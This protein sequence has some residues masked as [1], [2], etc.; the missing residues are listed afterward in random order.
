MNLLARINRELEGDVP[1]DAF[2]HRA[3]WNE[4]AA[5]IEMHLEAVRDAAFTV[6]GRRFF[7]AAGETIHTENSHKFDRRSQNT[8]LLAGGW[9]PT[10]RWTDEAG[11]FSL[12]L[13]EWTIPRGAP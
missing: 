12:V 4:D 1:L 2:R 9:T 10:H 7:V 6:A 11:R 8:L 5:R 3:I 13:A